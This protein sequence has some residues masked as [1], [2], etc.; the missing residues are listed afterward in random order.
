MKYLPLPP[1]LKAAENMAVRMRQ[2]LIKP[3]GQSSVLSACQMLVFLMV[4][5]GEYDA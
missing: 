5:P 2:I 3:Q 1:S 4:T